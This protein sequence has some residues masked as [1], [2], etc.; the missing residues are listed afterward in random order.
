MK[1]II[2][3]SMDG[4]AFEDDFETA[5]RMIMVQAKMKILRQHSDDRSSV[6]CTT[7]EAVHKLLDI[8]GNTVG[9]VKVVK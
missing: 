2:E 6:V 1:A 3:F 5:V 9:S 4:A 7:P 8:N